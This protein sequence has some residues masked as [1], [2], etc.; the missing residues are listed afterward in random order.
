[1]PNATELLPSTAGSAEDFKE[2]FLISLPSFH[3]DV[4][5]NLTEGR[6]PSRRLLFDFATPGGVADLLSGA[7]SWVA[8]AMSQ[9][10]SAVGGG[11]VAQVLSGATPYLQQGLQFVQACWNTFLGFAQKM[12]QIFQAYAP[13]RPIFNSP[14][15]LMQLLTNTA[16]IHNLVV[17]IQQLL[18]T[19]GVLRALGSVSQQVMSIFAKISQ[20]VSAAMG[21]LTG[22]R[23]LDSRE[24]EHLL[25]P[26]G[27]RLFGYWDMLNGLNFGYLVNAF[28][29]FVSQ[30]G[31]YANIL[32]Q[33]NAVLGPVLQQVGA[34]T[35]R[36]LQAAQA[37]AA[38]QQKYAWALQQVVPAWKNIENLGIQMC[39]AV[40]SMR[41]QGTS[42]AC[43]IQNFV[44]RGGV[45]GMLGNLLGTCPMNA[46]NPNCPSRPMSAGTADR[47]SRF[48][49]P[50]GMVIAALAACGLLGAGANALGKSGQQGQFRQPGQYQMPRF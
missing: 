4:A 13:L 23:R 22:G 45:L 18:T 50:L 15:G 12:V 14:D 5:A 30:A 39:P 7:A 37:L 48:A 20:V 26:A 36:R 38:N 29:T 3:F 43:R 16:N 42:L 6:A 11:Q 31:Q 34:M 33:V 46:G 28:A 44:G 1:V 17:F 21:R 9:L 49:G 47:L 40:A 25:G 19:S 41:G 8:N 24:Q 32:D 10:A 27:R 2:D 35:G